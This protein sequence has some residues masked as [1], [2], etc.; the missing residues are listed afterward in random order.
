MRISLPARPACAI[1]VHMQQRLIIPLE[2]FP[3]EGRRLG[4]ELDGALFGIDDDFLRSTGPLRYELE[5]QLYDTELMVRGRAS[6]PFRL[7]CNRCL[8]EFDYEVEVE[9]IILT[10][11]V[12]GK[13]E[14]DLTEQ[15]REELVLCLPDYPKCEL[16]GEECE[17][18]KN[19]SYGD[20]R[21]DKDPQSGVDSATPSGESVWDALDQ[22]PRQ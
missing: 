14:A 3:E 13:L 1:L 12:K 10:E 4:G 21:L 17:M 16:V 20:F 2:E 18:Q 8:E 7:R 15:L 5:A 11:D 6:A 19:A 9:D 22:I